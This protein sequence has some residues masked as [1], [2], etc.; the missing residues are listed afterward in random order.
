MYRAQATAKAIR[1]TKSGWTEVGEFSF[2]SPGRDSLVVFHSK[3]DTILNLRS[4]DV[5]PVQPDEVGLPG[6]IVRAGE[7]WRLG[8]FKKVERFYGD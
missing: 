3:S 2:H 8:M 6:L 7:L 1:Q 5:N 4:Q